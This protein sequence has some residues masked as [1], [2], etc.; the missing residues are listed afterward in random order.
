MSYV[1]RYVFKCFFLKITTLG[2]Y[3]MLSGRVFHSVA[4]AA[5]STNRLPSF[6]VQICM[7]LDDLRCLVAWYQLNSSLKNF[8][9]LKQVFLIEC[10]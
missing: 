2:E 4:A 7:V 1:K 3:L 10:V 6:T 8:E 5:V 9:N